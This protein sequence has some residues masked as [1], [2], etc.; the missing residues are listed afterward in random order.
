[1]PWNG[2]L[3]V[4]V[5]RSHKKQ[6]WWDRTADNWGSK[7]KGTRC[8][9]CPAGGPSSTT[10][11]SPDSGHRI[12][13]C[14]Q[15]RV[16]HRTCLTNAILKHSLDSGYRKSIRLDVI[17]T[18]DLGHAGN[19]FGYIHS[20]PIWS[21]FFTPYGTV[22]HHQCSKK[23]KLNNAQTKKWNSSSGSQK[24]YTW[25]QSASPQTPGVSR[26]PKKLSEVLK[27]DP[28]GNPP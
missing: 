1:M 17:S 4:V 3:L 8:Q 22:S 15:P 13:V 14:P 12:Q 11:H 25:L 7:G 24:S 5:C 21:I 28:F 20:S 23:Y 9:V 6:M 19:P 16:I 18:F 10:G 26:S 2:L 27:W